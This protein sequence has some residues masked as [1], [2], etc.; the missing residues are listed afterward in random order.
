ME[1]L[2]AA[3]KKELRMLGTLDGLRRARVLIEKADH[4]PRK[5]MHLCREIINLEIQKIMTLPENHFE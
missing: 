3:K 2:T 5:A 4:M 1:A